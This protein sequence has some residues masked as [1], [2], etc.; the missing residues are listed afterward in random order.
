MKEQLKKVRFGGIPETAEEYGK[1]FAETVGEPEGAAALFVLALAVFGEDRGTGTACLGMICADPP[2]EAVVDAAFPDS[3]EMRKIAG[4]YFQR[5]PDGGIAVTVKLTDEKP[6]RKDRRT[7][8]VG[9]AGTRSYRPLTLISKPPR[10]LKKRYGI[11][12]DFYN[13]PWLAEDYPSMIL[14]LPREKNGADI[15]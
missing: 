7:V 5:E 13:D 1:V 3:G 11:T 14:P 2:S 12:K 4:S 6:A 9:C 10:Y 8:Y 15:R